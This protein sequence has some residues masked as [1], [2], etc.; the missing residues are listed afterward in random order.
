MASGYYVGNG[1]AA[2]GVGAYTLVTD[3]NAN[4]GFSYRRN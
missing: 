4:P 3:G 2:L 1:T